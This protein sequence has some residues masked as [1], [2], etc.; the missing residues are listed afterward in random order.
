[1]KIKQIKLITNTD[2]KEV[3]ALLS[4][5]VEEA[6]LEALEILGY[7]LEIETDEE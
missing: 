6:A 3:I 5:N 1:M 7:T 2:L 4:T